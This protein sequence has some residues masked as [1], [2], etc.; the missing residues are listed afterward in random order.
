[1]NEMDCLDIVEGRYE[2]S[3]GSTTHGLIVQA[4]ESD[5]NA[6]GNKIVTNPV[7]AHKFN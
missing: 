5:Q 7:S 6:T 2:S 3:V 4:V 1:M